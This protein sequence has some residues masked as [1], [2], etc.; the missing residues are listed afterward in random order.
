MA[1]DSGSRPHRPSSR[2]D[3]HGAERR[4]AVSAAVRGTT[5]GAAHRRVAALY[6]CSRQ[7]AAVA[8]GKGFDGL[9]E[10]S[11]SGSTRLFTPG[12][13]RSTTRSSRSL[14]GRLVPE[15]GGLRR[16]ARPRRAEPKQA[17]R[18]AARR[19]GPEERPCARARSKPSASATAS[20]C[21]RGRSVADVARDMPVA[22][23]LLVPSTPT[24]TW[25][26]QFGRV[27][28]EAQ[29]SGAVVAGYATGSIPEV[30]GSRRACLGGDMSP[31]SQ[32]SVRVLTPPRRVCRASSTA[33]STSVARG[34]G[35]ALERVTPGCTNGSQRSFRRSQSS[36][37]PR[38]PD[39]A[40]AAEFGET[41]PTWPATVRL[42]CHYLR[43]GGPIS[44]ALARR[45]RHG[46]GSEGALAPSATAQHRS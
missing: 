31:L 20:R 15:K 6:P 21:S 12:T 41:A 30:A 2:R 28:V 18:A 37:S 9:I 26:E 46:C 11:L 45:D 27:I 4:Q 16:R 38:S 14:L 1:A 23:V 17:R 36:G 8:R 42:R 22:H 39:A 7:A 44:A 40:R 43:A 10:V 3:V 19:L 33:A 5:S 35:L 24:T 13:S 32:R 25:T 29:A 34:H